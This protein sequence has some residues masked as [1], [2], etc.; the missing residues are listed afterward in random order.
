MFSLVNPSVQ[1][2]NCAHYF[3]SD[4]SKHFQFLNIRAICGGAA[5][6]ENCCMFFASKICSHGKTMPPPSTLPT[7]SSTS[8]GSSPVWENLEGSGVGQTCKKI[9]IKLSD[10]KSASLMR[11]TTLFSLQSIKVSL[12]L[13]LITIATSQTADLLASSLPIYHGV[14]SVS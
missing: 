10:L 3:S 9:R 4:L 8:K 13:S 12:S 1:V 7:S 14:E 5:A 2:I 11:K 6:K